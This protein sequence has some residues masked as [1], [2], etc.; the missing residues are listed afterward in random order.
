MTENN[1]IH[2]YKEIGSSISKFRK[3]NR[4]SQEALAEKVGM[5]RASIVNIEKGRQFPPIHL[6]WQIS[7][8]LN[9]DIS[10]L[11][12]D[13]VCNKSDLN[14]SL[15]KIISKKKKQ[16]VLNND[17]SAYLTSFLTKQLG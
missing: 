10:Q 1:K 16:G 8:L 3:L 5:S 12:P 2:F 6:L 17:S 4:L 9:T 13:K 15:T 14:P 7:Q 11:I